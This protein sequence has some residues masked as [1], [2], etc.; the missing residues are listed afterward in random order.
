MMPSHAAVTFV[1]PNNPRLRMKAP[2]IDCIGAAR[3]TIS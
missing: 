3:M 2:A 1:T